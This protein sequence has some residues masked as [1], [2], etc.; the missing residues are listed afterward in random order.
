[1]DMESSGGRSVFQTAASLER[2]RSDAAMRRITNSR[3]RRDRSPLSAQDLCEGRA[4]CS[5]VTGWD[6]RSIGVCTNSPSKGYVAVQ[7]LLKEAEDLKNAPPLGCRAA[8]KGDNIFEW[9]A[10]IEG[11][12]DTVYKGGTFFLELTLPKSYPFEPPRVVFLTRIYHCNINSQGIVCVDVLRDRWNCCM[13]IS[14][15]L[16]SIVSLMYHCN[17]ADPLVGAIAE[18]YL[19]SREEFE[20]TARI[21]TQR[22]AR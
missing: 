3:P 1:M 14:T 6:P 7:R 9:A 5:K 4:E 20:R 21:W 22:Y 11:P 18:Q 17:P 13:T 2:A 15:V 10:V 19:R 8:P 12:E 16:Q